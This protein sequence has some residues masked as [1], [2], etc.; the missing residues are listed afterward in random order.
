MSTEVLIVLIVIFAL[1]FGGSFVQR[2]GIPYY[3]TGH[4]GGGL[5]GLIAIVVLILFV[6][7]RL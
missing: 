7:G 1:F 6:L 3:G 5:L 2:D 4:F